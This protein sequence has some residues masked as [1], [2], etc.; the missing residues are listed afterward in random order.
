M[1]SSRVLV[2]AGLAWIAFACQGTPVPTTAVVDVPSAE[3]SPEPEVVRD[4][5]PDAEP[6]P[7]LPP[8][9]D[10]LGQ[11]CTPGEPFCDARGRVSG[12]TSFVGFQDESLPLRAKSVHR[13]SSLD[14]PPGHS[15]EIGISGT[16][17]AIRHVTCAR[18]QNP[19]GFV[20]VGDLAR[21]SD[22]DLAGIQQRIGLPPSMPPLRAR[23]DWSRAYARDSGS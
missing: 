8:P 1:T 22:A 3:T 2:Q 21:L 13:E 14:T 5:G 20:F 19:Q 17:I 12:V 18:C 10:R 15:L 11:R 6:A 23:D 16:W 4:A 9:F 7:T